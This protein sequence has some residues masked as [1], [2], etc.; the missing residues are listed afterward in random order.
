[1]PRH[2]H[3]CVLLTLLLVTLAMKA[4]AAEFNV[5]DPASSGFDSSKLAQIETVM[6]KHIADGRLVGGMGLVARGNKIV[7]A[8]TWGQ[9]DR[10]NKLPMTDDTIFRI[11]S[12]S[13]PITSVAAMTLVEQGKLKLNDPVSKYLPELADRTV[14]IESKDGDGKRVLEEVPAK[15]EITI[16]DLMRHTSGFTYGFFGDSEVDKRYKRALVLITDRTLEDTITK[17]AKIPLKYQPGTRWHYSVSTDVLGRVIEVASGQTLDEYLAEQIFRP[18]GMKDTFFTVPKEKLSRLAQMYAPD[19]N[20]GLKPANPIKSFRFVTPSNRFYSGGGGLC[21]TTADYLAFC[22]MLI[23]DGK[24][25]EHRVL[26]KSSV[27]DMTKN[28]LHGIPQTSRS[29]QFGLGFAIDARGAY[30]WGGAA[31]T[32]FSIDPRNNLIIIYMVQI[33]PTGKFAYAGEM[34]QIVYSAMRR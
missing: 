8:K 11:Y 33:N 12:M 17:L 28:Q 4:E 20:G 19:R 2:S 16:R 27:R 31:G 7:F 13:K 9:R 3:R 18:L 25:G 22:Q 32:K 10:E 5:V 23:N 24:L 29:F 15:R 26:R 30:G 21:S 34:K 14:L 6:K 1:M